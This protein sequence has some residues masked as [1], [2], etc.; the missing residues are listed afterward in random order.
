[1]NKLEFFLFRGIDVQEFHLL[2]HAGTNPEPAGSEEFVYILIE[3]FSLFLSA[4]CRESN[5]D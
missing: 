4:G 5:G 3:D 1:M 2:L